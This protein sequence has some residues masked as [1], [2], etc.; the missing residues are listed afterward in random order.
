M[1]NGL[2]GKWFLFDGC[3]CPI[4]VLF[5]GFCPSFVHCSVL[6]SPFIIMFMM[7][8]PWCSL[9]RPTH[10]LD[11]FHHAKALVLLLTINS[12]C[13]TEC[14]S[15][16]QHGQKLPNTLGSP[17][18]PKTG[19]NVMVLCRSLLRAFTLCIMYY[20]ILCPIVCVA[21]AC[22]LRPD[23]WS[24]RCVFVCVLADIL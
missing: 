9:F 7:R 2:K 18:S 8:P 15:N 22:L 10:G 5:F 21:A 24:G 4:R 11:I 17:E 20:T 6:R 23:A 16:A 14:A 13:I 3:V 1:A 12:I 19:Q